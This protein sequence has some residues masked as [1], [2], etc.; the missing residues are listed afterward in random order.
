ML[1]LII[2][3]LIG[4][5]VKSL[6]DTAEPMEFVHAADDDAN[7]AATIVHRNRAP[8]ALA[9]QTELTSTD[10]SLAPDK[11]AE[12]SHPHIALELDV[13]PDFK[14]SVRLKGT[15]Y[16]LPGSGSHQEL[17]Q[18]AMNLGRCIWTMQLL[19]ARL[20]YFRWRIYLTVVMLAK[21]FTDCLGLPSALQALSCVK[22]HA[23]INIARPIEWQCSQMPGNAVK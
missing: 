13:K 21:L 20:H 1:A 16:L 19:H 23:L 17:V 8:E 12:E 2:T 5:G 14:V 10:P 6:S 18:L 11:Q 4:L 22:N 15:T 9:A 7:P 3:A